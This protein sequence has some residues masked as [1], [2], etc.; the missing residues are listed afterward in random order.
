MTGTIWVYDVANGTGRVAVRFPQQFH[1]AFRASWVDGDRAF[2]VNRSE[3]VSH[4]VLFD[5]FGESAATSR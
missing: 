2:V 4:V 1:V 3:T 5:R